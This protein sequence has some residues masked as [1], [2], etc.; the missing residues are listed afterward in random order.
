MLFLTYWFAAFAGVFFVTYWFIHRPYLRLLLLLGSCIIFQMHFAGP[1]GVLPIFLLAVLTYFCGLVGG[2]MATTLGIVASVLALAFYK[3]LT[4]LAQAVLNLFLPEGAVTQAVA[5]IGSSLPATPPLGI[6]FFVFEF[7]HYLF[8][9][10]RGHAPL[11]SPLLFGSFALFWPTLVAGPIKRYEQ[12]RPSLEEGLSRRNASDIATGLLRVAEGLVK[13]FIADYLGQ[14]IDYW[15]DSFSELALSSRWALVGAIALRIL[16]DFSGYSDIAI[17]FA[18]MIGVRIPENFW[19]PYLAVSPVEFWR[20]WHISLSSWVR[21]YIYIPLGGNLYGPVSRV[22]NLLI[23]FL[24]VGLWHGGGWNFILWGLYQGV[25]V[26][27]T[28][29][30][31][32]LLEPLHISRY[33]ATARIVVGVVGWASTMLFVTFGWL[34]FFYPLPQAL[35]MA[36]ALF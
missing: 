18:R 13:K 2:N 12:F 21:D 29:P 15:D 8:D 16:F 30:I 7:C 32:R 33:G 4:F 3:Y 10:K 22:R 35:E 26:A 14:M 11:R 31:E 24:L 9:V 27:V 25:G 34:L 17:G 36:R 6:S 1:A 23:A 20:R 5:A 28:A 19:W